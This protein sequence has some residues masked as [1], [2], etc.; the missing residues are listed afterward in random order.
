LDT[1]AASTQL[2]QLCDAGLLERKG[3]SVATHYVLGHAVSVATDATAPQEGVG[4]KI[5]DRP[6]LEADRPNLEADRPNLEA[7]RPNLAADR[8]NPSD[9]VQTLPVDIVSAIHALGE[10]PRQAPLRNV[11][12]AL[13]AWQ[14]LS[15]DELGHFLKMNS[16]N[17]SKRHL[18]A[19]VADGRLVRTHP[20]NPNHPAQAY[21]AAQALLLP[22][23]AVS[24]KRED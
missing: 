12:E 21:R 8:P 6:N 11:I 2:R 19:M 17:L 9:P 5:S 4:S 1:L 7:D 14:A 24:P 18:T 10:R 13:C 15:S 16:H 20:E 3:K 23:G 22:N